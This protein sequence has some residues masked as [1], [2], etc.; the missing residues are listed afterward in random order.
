MSGAHELTAHCDTPAATR[1]AGCCLAGALQPGDVIA[2]QG[3][4][5]AGKTVFVQGLGEG[6]G[7][8]G[9]VTSPTFVIMRRHLS[10]A[11]TAPMLYHV[12]A[13]RLGGGPELLDMGLDDWLADGAVA[14]EWA[15]NV[16]DALPDDHLE[17]RF[18]AD[19]DRRVL[20][21]VAHGPRARAL[22]EHLHR[23]GY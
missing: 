23:C 14:V 17:I 5:G 18:R 11:S 19:G 12:D 6:L 7:A 9:R 1:A 8:V 22:L 13:Y 4:L 15:G 20:T 2:L 21:I 10:S 16:A 3:E